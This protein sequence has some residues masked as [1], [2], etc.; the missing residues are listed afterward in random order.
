VA[1]SLGDGENAGGILMASHAPRELCLT[2][3]VGRWRADVRVR[4]I[5][6]QRASEACV[7][8]HLQLTFFSR[9]RPRR[10]LPPIRASPR[11]PARREFA[12]DTGSIPSTPSL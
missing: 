7:G 12:Y 5:V 10:R 6:G 4:A 9:L 11:T 8:M 3:V 1:F 2:L